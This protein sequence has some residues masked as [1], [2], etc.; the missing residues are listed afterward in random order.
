MVCWLKESQSASPLDF[1]PTQTY[2]PLIPWHGSTQLAYSRG[3]ENNPTSLHYSQHPQ[4][5]EGSQTLQAQTF[6]GSSWAQILILGFLLYLCVGHPNISACSASLF[7]LLEGP[8]R[9]IK[10]ALV[11]KSDGAKAGKMHTIGVLISKVRGKLKWL[12]IP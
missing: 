10:S 8:D 12:S 7:I 1:Q 9:D 11:F 2:A 3:I 5:W 4:A 6:R